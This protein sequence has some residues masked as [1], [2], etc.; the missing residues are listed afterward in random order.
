[1]QWPPYDVLPILNT[2]SSW[3]LPAFMKTRIKSF[4]RTRKRVRGDLK[5]PL[6]TN[7][8]LQLTTNEHSLSTR[9]LSS[10]PAPTTVSL[11]LFGATS[12]AM[13]TRYSSSKLQ[14]RTSQR[15][16]SL[17]RACTARCTSGSTNGPRTTHRM[18]TCRSSYGSTYP[19]EKYITL[20]HDF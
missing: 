9:S 20:C 1:M 7:T 17:K 10:G 12:K 5:P 11:P 19:D 8:S 3:S 18:T 6:Y 15:G 14:R 16:R 13:S 2:T 4:L